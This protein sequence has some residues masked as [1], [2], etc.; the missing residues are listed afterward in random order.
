MDTCSALGSAM[1]LGRRRQDSSV[2]W[3]V[4]QNR[5]VVRIYID[6]YLYIVS[7]EVD[8]VQFRI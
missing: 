1:F 6:R 3:P 7:H 5:L 4:D 8:D 2:R